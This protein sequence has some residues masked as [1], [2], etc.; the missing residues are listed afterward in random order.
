MPHQC[1]FDTSGQVSFAL[2]TLPPPSHTCQL[3][4]VI[5]WS[6]ISQT[7]A[8][9]GPLTFVV[10]K[11]ASH[12]CLVHASLTSSSHFPIQTAPEARSCT[13]Q[14]VLHFRCTSPLHSSPFSLC[15]CHAKGFGLSKLFLAPLPSAELCWYLFFMYAFLHSLV[16]LMIPIL[17]AHFFIFRFSFFPN[18]LV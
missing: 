8:P 12:T 2:I 9:A 14:V 5:S 7:T 11:V 16:F 18:V 4:T 10:H 13:C 15:W 1:L 17:C 6:F 3:G